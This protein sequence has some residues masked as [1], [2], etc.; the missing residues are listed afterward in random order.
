MA[1]FHFELVEDDKSAV[2]Q[3]LQHGDNKTRI[4]CYTCNDIIVNGA[5]SMN[6]YDLVVK[7]ITHVCR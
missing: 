1:N 2:F 7:L 5:Y 3:F 6:R 4:N